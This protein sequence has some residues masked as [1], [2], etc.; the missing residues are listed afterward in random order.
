[1]CLSAQ[2]LD[3][4]ITDARVL[5]PEFVPKDVV[6]RDG[7]INHLTST[8][9]PVMNG[10]T[11]EPSFLYGPSGTGKTCI[12]LF[13]L[14]K[15][16]ETLIDVETQYVN[17]W[18]DHSRYTVL[19]RLLE[20][21]DKT[22]DIHRQST[23]TDVLLNRL[24]DYD[25]PPFIAILD[26]VD[27]LQDKDLLYELHRIPGLSLVLIANDDDE[28]FAQVSDRVTSRLQTSERIHFNPY[29]QDELIAI[30]DDRVRWGLQKDVID[31]EQIS[32]IAAAAGGDAHVALGVLRVAAK[33]AR[34]KGYDRI[35]ATVV[36]QA[37]SE[38]KTEIKQ[39]TLDKLTPDQTI[40][41]D[42]I[43]EHGEVTPGTLYEEYDERASNPRSERMVRNYLQKL[44]HYNLIEALGQ[45]RGRRYRRVD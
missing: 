20:G 24:R 18:A 2:Y 34:R 15:L 8:L 14:D 17:C 41:Y 3:T 6:H 36:E 27:Q 1:M 9:K 5:D 7:E 4:M 37:V 19:Y 29:T 32:Q 31:T 26:E 39:Q 22:F 44:V 13:A 10:E 11:A 30:L 21:L 45:N 33:R 25:S 42:I 16:R 23:P 12:A 28:F 43:T 35:D 40:L 38:A